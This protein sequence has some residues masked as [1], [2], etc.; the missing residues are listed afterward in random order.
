MTDLIFSLFLNCFRF[1]FDLA[2]F[3]FFF[4]SGAKFSFAYVFE[5]KIETIFVITHVS[6]IDYLQK[7][8]FPVNG[9]EMMDYELSL[10]SRSHHEGM[11]AERQ[12][13][14]CII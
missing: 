2:V 9:V 10:H 7:F 4:A 1:Y 13:V 6:I 14:V 12:D 5:F 3:L 8:Q 11:I